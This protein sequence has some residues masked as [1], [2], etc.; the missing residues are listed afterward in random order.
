MAKGFTIHPDL[1]AERNAVCSDN[2]STMGWAVA[3]RP[4]ATVI[5]GGRKQ[6][7]ANG[8]RRSYAR[9]AEAGRRHRGHR[10]FDMNYKLGRYTPPRDRDVI[11]NCGP[12]EKALQRNARLRG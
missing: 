8:M 11:R 12:S 7:F 1:T 6:H 9:F 5:I 4:G 10:K 3:N 2:Q